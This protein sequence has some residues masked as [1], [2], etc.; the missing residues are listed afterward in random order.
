MTSLNEI[1]P[2]WLVGRASA[3]HSVQR[4]H[5]LSRWMESRLGRIYMVPYKSSIL[6]IDL[7]YD[8]SPKSEPTLELHS[9]AAPSVEAHH[10]SDGPDPGINS[11][12][13]RKKITK[14]NET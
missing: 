6:N 9:R 14:P 7:L 2:W 8:T 10:H 3:S 11:G 13:R 5:I 4:R 1:Q 12:G